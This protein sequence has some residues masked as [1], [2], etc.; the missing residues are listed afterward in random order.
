[1]GEKVPWLVRGSDDLRLGGG[2][3]ASLDGRTRGWG[4][5]ASLGLGARLDAGLLADKRMNGKN[6]WQE[7]A[8][9]E[10]R[11]AVDVV[12]LGARAFGGYRGKRVGVVHLGL[13]RGSS[14]ATSGRGYRSDPAGDYISRQSSRDR[15]LAGGPG[16]RAGLG[17]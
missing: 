9:V 12:C 4:D 10:R 5:L 1:M 2:H 13:D 8:T 7:I 15:D 6:D 14:R 3:G 11:L 16:A 17:G